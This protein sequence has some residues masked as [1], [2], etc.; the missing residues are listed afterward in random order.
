MGITDRKRLRQT[1]AHA[2][3]GS[4]CDYKKLIGIHTGILLLVSLAVTLVDYLLEEQIGQTAGLSGV[5][6]RS[7]LTS[8][9]SALTIVQMIGLPFWQFGWVFGAMRL[10]RG[11]TADINTLLEGFRRFF[12]LLRLML[13]QGI[14]YLV[15][16]I[17][18]ANAGMFFF[19]MTPWAKP[20]MEFYLRAESLP[21]EQLLLA[22]EEVVTEIALPMM[23]IQLLVFAVVAIPVAYRL[24][25]AQYCLLDDPKGKAWAAIKRSVLITKRQSLALFRLDVSFWWFYAL[26]VLVTAVAYVDVV[27]NLAGVSLGIAPWLAYFG[28]FV[29]YGLCQLGLYWWKKPQVDATYVCA[30]E[31]LSQMHPVLPQK[32]WKSPW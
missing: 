21:Q 27:L 13:L 31:A 28:S 17:A 16:G 2:L 9:Q 3:Q 11:G 8:V 30:Y 24:R 10:T 19:A 22:M 29:L 6:L 7:V 32:E 25:M 20:L 15:I 26:D 14:I 23:A 12:P 18:T 1:A 5:K 4:P